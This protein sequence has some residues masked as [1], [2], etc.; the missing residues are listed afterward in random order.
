MQIKTIQ[1]ADY[2]AVDQLVHAA[3]SQTEHGYDGE[4]E[5]IHA[6]RQDPAYQAYLEVV[7]FDPLQRPIGVG[8]LSPITIGDSPITGLALA[9]LAVDPA[10]QKQGVGRRIIQK[11]EQRARISGGAY[12]SVLGWPDYY[13]QFGYRPASAFNVQAP[14]DD[15][16]EDYY[17]LKPLTP[18]GLEGI[19]GTVGYLPAFQ[20]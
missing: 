8:L 20:N 15:V 17:L 2:D 19:H 14:W 1:P 12:I 16:P 13:G 3:F 18:S 9:P 5:L 11:L 6:L 10:H 7:A 4:V